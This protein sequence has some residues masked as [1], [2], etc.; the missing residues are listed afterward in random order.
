MLAVPGS[1]D[2]AS[3]P[4]EDEELFLSDGSEHGSEDEL[5]P[6]WTAGARAAEEGAP[7]PAEADGGGHTPAQPCREPSP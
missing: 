6:G 1:V 7:A 2:P 4:L 3:A 5:P